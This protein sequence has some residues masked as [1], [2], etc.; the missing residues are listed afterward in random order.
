MHQGRGAWLLP[1]GRGALISS[2]RLSQRIDYQRMAP[3]YDD[4]RD[5]ALDGLDEWQRAITPYVTAGARIG[6]IGAGT[7]I[8][9]R[10]FVEWF[11]DVTVVAVEPSD[12]MRERAQ[13]KRAHPRI[14]YRAGTA[15][16][17]PV[18]DGALD[19][20]W[21]SAVVHHIDRRSA[22][23]SLMRALSPGGHLLIRGA[24]PGRTE[25]ITLFQYFPT[26]AEKLAET[27][28]P[29]VT[30]VGELTEAGF[31]YVS[32]TAVPQTSARNLEELADKAATRADSSLTRIADQDFAVGLRALREA[33]ASDTQGAP[34]VDWL[35][36]AVFRARC[37]R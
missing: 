16:D 31:E 10:A 5:L 27:Y 21:L 22:A 34:V 13:A 20:A 24:W 23:R 29:L 30:V 37:K 18:E 33:A 4:G 7:G 3:R 19:V 25:R 8:F 32:V 28:P 6:D 17:L 2:L 11:P 15:E 14:E 1:T 26:A 12:A 35:D 9:A 36:L